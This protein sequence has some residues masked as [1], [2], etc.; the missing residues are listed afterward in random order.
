M[1]S[2]TASDSGRLPNAASGREIKAE[3]A[4]LSL[5]GTEHEEKHRLETRAAAACGG[6]G[7]AR[8]S[9]LLTNTGNEFSVNHKFSIVSALCDLQHQR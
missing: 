6:G 9:R 2:E 1:A 7:R 5:V 3:A 4:V 8:R